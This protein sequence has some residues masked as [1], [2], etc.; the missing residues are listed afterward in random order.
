MT[1]QRANNG[2]ERRVGSLEGCSH[3]MHMRQIAPFA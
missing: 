3:D 2:E 1:V